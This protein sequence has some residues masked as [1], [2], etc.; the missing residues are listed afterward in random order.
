MRTIAVANQK[1]GCGKTTTAVNLAAALAMN[2]KRV[3]LVDLDPQAHSTLGL[4][5]DPESLD[6]TIYDALTNPKVAMLSVII[7][8]PVTGLNL[9]PNNILLS[10]AE[11]ELAS[12]Y[13]REYVLGQQLNTVSGYYD[14]CVIDCSPSLN[15]LTLNAL[16]AADEVIIPVQTH[17]YALEGLKQLL[18][19]INIVRERF[20]E[21]LSIVGILLTLVESR[22]MLSRQIQQQM[23]D[24]F[25]DMVFDTVIHRTV[26]LAEAPGA[27]QSVITYAPDSKATAEY[28]AL[29]EEILHEHEAQIRV[30]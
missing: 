24:Y 14:I 6:K 17:Y 21:R 3:L 11:Y 13:G 1:G 7:S 15:L 10:G 30:A 29:A 4:G 28:K 23:R 9:A 8:T 25:G 12:L 22:T 27:G 5:H 16:V 18:E 2:G 26:R 20:N 19:T